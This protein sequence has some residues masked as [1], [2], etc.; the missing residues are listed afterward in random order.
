MSRTISIATPE[1][2]LVTYEVAGFASRFLASLIDL[3]IQLLLLLGLWL[4]LRAIASAFAV[5]GL[6]GYIYLVLFVLTFV[7][8][9]AYATIFEML[10][11]GRT[12][13]KR[14]LGLRVIREGGYPI[15]LVASSIRNVL[16]I[17]D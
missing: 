10:W 6:G 15:N 1:N 8:Q 16:R 17:I 4:C 7:V 14:L 5:L 3:L 12:P 2:I 9:F 11:G 13:G